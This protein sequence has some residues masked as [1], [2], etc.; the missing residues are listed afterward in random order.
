MRGEMMMPQKHPFLAYCE[1]KI[2]IWV[3]ILW[4][5]RNTGDVYFIMVADCPGMLGWWAQIRRSYHSLHQNLPFVRSEFP[6]P[7]W[8]RDIVI[9]A[10]VTYRDVGLSLCAVKGQLQ[11]FVPVEE[12]EETLGPEGGNEVFVLEPPVEVEHSVEVQSQ[13][14]AVVHQHTQFLPLRSKQNPC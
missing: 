6:P 4:G 5:G 9:A 7:E 14:A 10:R 2:L 1:N 13:T 11:R 3:H 8:K 12:G